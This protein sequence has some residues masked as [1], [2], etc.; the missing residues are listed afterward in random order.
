MTR[1][2]TGLERR[3]HA[4]QISL[5]D[6]LNMHLELVT[7]QTWIFESEEQFVIYECQIT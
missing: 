5:I 3:L 2:W 1:E 4:V 7:G 6:I